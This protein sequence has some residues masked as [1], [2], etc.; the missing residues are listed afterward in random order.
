MTSTPRLT[1]MSATDVRQRAATAREHLQVAWERLE[2][3]IANPGPSE[4][5]QVAA[6]NAVLAGIAAA[7]AICG[8]KLHVRANDQ[9]HRAAVGLTATIDPGGKELSQR[10]LRLLR[11]KTTLQYGGFCTAATAQQTVTQAAA[12]VD[13]L[14]TYLP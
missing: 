2:L 14:D 13:A 4:L 12:L 3:A 10:L 9:D 1:P 5:A 7:D 6:S 8:A 11:N